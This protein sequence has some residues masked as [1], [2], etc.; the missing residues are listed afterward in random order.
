[1]VR[2]C[3]GAGLERAESGRDPANPVGAGNHIVGRDDHEACGT[4]LAARKDGIEILAVWCRGR[5]ATI[6][7]PPGKQGDVA[8][9][10]EARAREWK[11]QLLQEGRE[12]DRE[13]G[14]TE[15]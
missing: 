2:D 5:E 1:M 11:A 13:E 4:C 7:M 15:G 9:L 14:R 8:T 6:P 10:A 12:E 3:C